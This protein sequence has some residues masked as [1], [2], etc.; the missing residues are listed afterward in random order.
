MNG[1]CRS[2]SMKVKF[3]RGSEILGRSTME[4]T[5]SR[6]V[7]IGTV[8]LIFLISLSIPYNFGNQR[9]DRFR[10]Y[11]IIIMDRVFSINREGTRPQ[12]YM[13][14]RTSNFP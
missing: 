4:M 11:R 13:V 5:S 10:I 12:N 8:I 1:I 6:D 14:P 7:R 2:P 9:C 3:P